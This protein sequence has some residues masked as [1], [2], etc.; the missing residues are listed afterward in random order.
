[1]EP[2][3]EISFVVGR[4]RHEF[5]KV[6]L[7][8]EGTELMVHTELTDDMSRQISVGVVTR[9]R[10]Q[11]KAIIEAV[12]RGILLSWE[13]VRHPE[14]GRYGLFGRRSLVRD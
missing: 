13:D 5:P 12:M 7:V 6:G 4:E 2:G 3:I 9:G 1:M 11:A 10:D 14:T 8:L